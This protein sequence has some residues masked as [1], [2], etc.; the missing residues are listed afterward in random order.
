MPE[1]NLGMERYAHSIEQAQTLACALGQPVGAAEA[2]VTPI[3]QSTTFTRSG[4]HDGAEHQYSRV[5]N[6]TVSALE[7]ALARLEGAAGAV[8][9]ATGLAAE[10]A[11]LLAL[12]R[13]GDRVV[14]GRSVYGGTTRLLREILE[15]L[16]VEAVF[17]DASNPEAIDALVDERTRVVFVETPANPTLE[18]TDVRA[19]AL[20]AGRVGAA[21]VVDNTFLTSVIQRPLGLGADASVYSTT[22]FIEGHSA[23]PGGAVVSSDEALLERVR[24]V[25]KSTGAIQ[26]PLHAWLTLQGIKT[27]P[28]RIARQSRTAAALARELVGLPGLKRV[29]HPALEGFGQERLACEQHLG[30]LHGAVVTIELDE[31]ACDVRAFLGALRLCRLAEHVGSVESLVTHPATMTHA[32]VPAGQRRAA[33]LSDGLVRVSVGLESTSAIAEDLTRALAVSRVG[34]GGRRTSCAPALGGGAV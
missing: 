7:S 25:R 10:T 32:D 9:F 3:V 12:V 34:G 6:P 14:C 22:K 21:L 18:L 17:V 4:T 8:A 26:T 31:E 27:L 19:A 16:G 20:S 1:R 2:L 28:L 15:P 13:A 30:G 29:V 11:L 23:A 24:R 33:G 5:S